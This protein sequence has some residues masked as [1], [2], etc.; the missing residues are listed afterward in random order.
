MGGMPTGGFLG[1]PADF[2]GRIKAAHYGKHADDQWTL[3][4]MLAFAL[5]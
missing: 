4:E 5:A 2:L 1:L 3:D